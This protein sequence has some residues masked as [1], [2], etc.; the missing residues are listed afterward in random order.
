MVWDIVRLIFGFIVF[1]FILWGAYIASR[2]L[3][4]KNI[5]GFPAK[6]MKL[7]DRTQLTKDSFLCIVQ[8]GER[9]FLM[10]ISGSEMNLISELFEEDLILIQ[11][12]GEISNPIDDIKKLLGD[13]IGNIN[14]KVDLK[15]DN[16]EKV[17]F[18]S[19]F[20]SKTDKD[21]SAMDKLI[22][23]SR[24][25]TDKLRRKKSNENENDED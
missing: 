15:K 17:D 4:S 23:E 12:T 22:E 10:G 9:Y 5:M 13:K 7:I 16:S 20:R 2:W 14:K 3:A 25:K 8:V 11:N 1:C 24:D 19:L 18:Q 6:Y 21:F